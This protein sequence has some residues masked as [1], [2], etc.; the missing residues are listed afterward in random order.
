[1]SDLIQGDLF[2]GDQDDVNELYRQVFQYRNGRKFKDMAG[3]GE[4]CGRGGTRGMGETIGVMW[5][6]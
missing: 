4:T 2:V 3:A 1:M 5:E 6:K